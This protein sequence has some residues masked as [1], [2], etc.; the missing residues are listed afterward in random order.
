MPA[1]RKVSGGDDRGGG[2]KPRLD[3]DP[4]PRR[5]TRAPKPKSV[6]SP[7]AQP[8]PPE[9]PVPGPTKSTTLPPS[10]RNWKKNLPRS[11]GMSSAG[12]IEFSADI[13][14]RAAGVI[15]AMS[16]RRG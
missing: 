5:S 10:S 16:H 1:K 11:H 4:A 6:F 3:P 14:D 7:S 15:S 2:K 9:D 13:I 12:I 8:V